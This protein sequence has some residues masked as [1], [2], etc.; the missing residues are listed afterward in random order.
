MYFQCFIAS[1]L[2]FA[3]LL[4]SFL[5]MSVSQEQTNLLRNKI[6]GDVA[7]AYEKIIHERSTIYLQGILLGL[8][9]STICVYIMK[10]TPN[11]F[12]KTMI[13]VSVTLFTAVI[14]Y[15]VVPKSDYMLH[16]L[17]SE[18]QIHTW[19]QTYRTMQSRYMIG[20]VL[21]AIASIPFSFAYC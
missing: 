19:F 7:I 3:L 13:Y 9:L 21:G 5:T 1:F 4:G 17:K 16:H 14:Y 12:Y 15:M 8:I 2:G 10:Q 6:S 20:F 11:R 18:E